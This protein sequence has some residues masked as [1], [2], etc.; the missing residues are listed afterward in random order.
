[1]DIVRSLIAF[2]WADGKLVE[3]ESQ[4]VDAM[5]CGFDASE[6]ERADLAEYAKVPRTL[7]DI[8]VGKLRGHHREL[9]LAN[10]ALLTLSDG[11]QVGIERVLLGKLS[12]LLGFKGEEADKIVATATDGAIH[13]PKDALVPEKQPPL[14]G[15]RK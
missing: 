1:M 12:L 11:K 4:V 6:Q 5:L 10:A 3:E 15:S 7:S 8:P 9:L 13:L 14:P 2:G